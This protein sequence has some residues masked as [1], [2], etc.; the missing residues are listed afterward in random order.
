MIYFDLPDPSGRTRKKK[1]A[2]KKA[3]KKTAKKAK[4]KTAKKAKR[5]TAKKAPTR[6]KAPFSESRLQGAFMH[7]EDALEREGQRFSG[8][9]IAEAIS[10]RPSYAPIAKHYGLAKLGKAWTVANKHL[11][12]DGNY[13]N[14]SSYAAGY[15][16][17]RWAPSSG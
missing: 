6:G 9:K 4:K 16:L 8:A 13:Y 7:G 17:G 2:K 3:K 12:R 1:A 14:R 15:L 5:K 10:E 11:G